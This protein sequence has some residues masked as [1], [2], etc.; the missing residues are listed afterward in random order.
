MFVR[1]VH[2]AA[3]GLPIFDMESAEEVAPD[4]RRVTT[5]VV[6]T[7]PTGLEVTG[8]VSS[9]CIAGKVTQVVSV[10]NAEGFPVTVTAKGPYGSKA[11][12]PLAA[13]KTSSATFSTRQTTI[14]EGTVTVDATATVNGKAVTDTVSLPFAAARCG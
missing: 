9:H 10:R 13:G 5:T 4:N 6:V 14:P 2:F 7:A 8:T 3:D 11:F 1:R 12:G